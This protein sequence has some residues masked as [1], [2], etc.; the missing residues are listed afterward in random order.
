[1]PPA[2]G[3]MGCSS[4]ATFAYSSL[5]PPALPEPLHA[6]PLFDHF[7]LTLDPGNRTEAAGPFFYSEQKDSQHLWALPP[8]FSWTRD[9]EID[10]EEIDFAY[11]ILTYDRYGDQYRW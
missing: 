1:M 11:P 3:I 2:R 6:G 7:D 8:L 10:S 5:E 4:C 9:P